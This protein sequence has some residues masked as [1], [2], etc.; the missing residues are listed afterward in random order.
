MVGKSSPNFG[1]WVSA[2]GRQLWARDGGQ[3]QVVPP[4]PVS[5]FSHPRRRPALSH[6][7]L[8][9]NLEENGKTLFVER[10]KEMGGQPGNLPEARG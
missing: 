2:A 1:I 9:G 3:P 6:C 8:A 10:I 7:R 4:V 5:T